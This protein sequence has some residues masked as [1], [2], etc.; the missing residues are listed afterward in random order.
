MIN[1]YLNPFI[2][3]Y[4]DKHF[5]ARLLIPAFKY[6]FAGVLLSFVLFHSPAPVFAAEPARLSGKYKDCNVILIILDALRPEHLSCYGYPEKTSPNIDALAERGVIFS[7]A[8]STAPYTM[9]AVASIFTSLYPYSH[10]M[11]DAFKDGLSDNIYTLAQIFDIYGYNTVWFGDLSDPHS[12]SAMG[13]LNGFRS[14]YNL[15]QI[16]QISSNTLSDVPRWINKNSRGKFFLTVHSYL[17]HEQ[18]FPFLRADNKFHRRVPEEFTNELESLRRS[19][20]LNFSKGL[21]INSMEEKEESVRLY[22]A[23]ADKAFRFIDRLDKD[24]LREFLSLLDSAVYEVDQRLIGGIVAELK[25]KGIYD[26]TIIVIT[27]DH[28]NEFKEHGSFGHGAYLY[29]E[30]IRVPLVYYLPGLNKG[31]RVDPLAQSIDTLPTLLDLLSIPVPE[32]AQG[33]S[34]VGILEDK[35]RSPAHEFVFSQGVNNIFSIR[36]DK[37]KYIRGIK[38]SP[39]GGQDPYE[40]L[41]DL[42]NDSPEKNDLIVSRPETARMLRDRLERWQ[43]DLVRYNKE[44]REFPVDIPEETRKRIKKT[45]YW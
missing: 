20:E 7:S 11:M 18:F 39:K 25:N 16:G 33:R 17:T 38:C 36:S 2:M 15:H 10:N 44:E 32:Q 41:F 9:P 4:A 8:F 5:I 35:S 1:S 40:H 43:K 37:W 3:P 14:K 6:F 30:S 24:R 23:W 27:A 28:G 12:G 22:S 42:Q 13:M 19:A 31:I 34:L 45:G 21:F 26:K 29:D